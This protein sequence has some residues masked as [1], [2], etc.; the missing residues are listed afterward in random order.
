MP[1]IYMT[2][3]TQLP[4]F[5]RE[6][7]SMAQIFPPDIEAAR[8][9]GESPDELETLIA[10]RDGLPDDF[11]VYHGVHWSAVRP[12]YTD[13]GEIDFVVVNK[14]GD[15]LVIEQKNG[16][17]I[18]SSQGLEKAYY[19]GKKKLVYT[20]VNRNLG[21]GQRV[22]Q[23][24]KIGGFFRGHNASDPCN[25]QNIALFSGAFGDH[26]KGFGGHDDT[27]LGGGNT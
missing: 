17:L 9:D 13:F 4:P 14:A 21:N 27:A 5:A 20:Q 11:V 26:R 12:K 23:W 6:E 8:A 18:E 3:Q 24:D 16:P 22:T 2:M 1:A 15:V 25:P 7:D 10:L 19:G